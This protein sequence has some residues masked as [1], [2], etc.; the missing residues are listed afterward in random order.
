MRKNAVLM[1]IVVVAL[2]FFALTSVALSV[3]AAAEDNHLSVDGAWVLKET[4]KDPMVIAETGTI[5]TT[6]MVIPPETPPFYFNYR[7]GIDDS[8]AYFNWSWVSVNWYWKE[9]VREITE[10]FCTGQVHEKSTWTI[11]PS[12]L[13]PGQTMKTDLEAS[14][15][16]SQDV[17]QSHPSCYGSIGG[18]CIGFSITGFRGRSIGP[19]G[20]CVGGNRH[21][22]G[23]KSSETVEWSVPQGIL[24]DTLEIKI[25]PITTGMGMSDNA[26]HFIYEYKE[27]APT[28]TPPTPTPTTTTPPTPTPTDPT[29]PIA[30]ALTWKGMDKDKVSRGNGPN[31]D[32]DPDGHFS[33]T[34]T[35]KD[36]KTINRITVLSTDKSGNPVGGQVWNTVPDG[37][38][39]LGVEQPSGNRLNPTD[40]PIS[41]TITTTTTFE[42]YGANSGWFK[43][44]QHFKAVVEFTDGT[45]SEAI[46]TVSKTTT[47]TPTPGK[48]NKCVGDL[49]YLYVEDRVM[50]SGKT[51]KIP[52]MMCNAKDLA[53]MDIDWSYDASVLKIIEVTKGSLNKKALFDW[54][55]V[56]A[57]KLKIS[58]ASSKG[59]TGSGSIAVMKFEVIGNTGDTSTLTGTV[60]T[61]S[62]TDGS[63]LSVSVNPGKFTVGSSPVKG[64]CDGDGE[65]TVKDALAALQMSV[66]KRAVDICYDYN[67][68]GKVNSADARDM[69]KAIVG[70]K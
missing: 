28:T 59:V 46:T 38:W 9:G 45:S 20:P 41:K 60:T 13:V 22:S 36:A 66:E 65:L 32:G 34:L 11:P 58:F 39:I 3:G 51:V 69:L 43:E 53:N 17:I 16:A 27:E 14:F 1:K 15:T 61:A 42:L 8:S 26:I 7:A 35:P 64:D 29:T 5:P 33:L 62:K 4:I 57:G 6:P 12:T 2:V 55:E 21:E 48:I 52:I 47:P 10:T 63:K 23:R 19:V 44:G 30:S 54:N 40:K 50:G 37:N 31:P 49:P 56:S 70:K 68:D 24:G 18:H 25:A 67:D